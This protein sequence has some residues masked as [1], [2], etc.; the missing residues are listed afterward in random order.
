MRRPHAVLLAVVLVLAFIAGLVLA[1]ATATAGYDD[2][3]PC[4]YELCGS[5]FIVCCSTQSCCV[6]P[7]GCA[8]DPP[9]CW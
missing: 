2:P 8:G 6:P 4:H 7:S 5:E 3:P 9:V 1:P